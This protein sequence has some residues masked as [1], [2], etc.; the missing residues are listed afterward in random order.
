LQIRPVTLNGSAFTGVWA[1]GVHVNA[2]FGDVS[3]NGVADGLD[4]AFANNV[5]Q[6]KSTGFGAYTLLDPAIIGDVAGDVSVDA[7]DVSSLAA[8]VL[9]LPTPKI[10]AIPTGPA[11]TP[12]GPDPTLSLSEQGGVRPRSLRANGGVINVSVRLDQPHPAGSS[13][14]TEAILAL[15]YDP[16]VLS[17]SAS[18]ITLGSLPSL[19]AGWQLSSVIDAATGQIGIEL[20]S[21]TAITATQ[22]GSLVNIVFHVVPGAPAGKTSVQLVR[23][24]MPG[25]EQFTTQVDA[26]EGSLVLGLGSERLEMLLPRSARARLAF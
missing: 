15:T 21:T 5:A 16:S 1:D 13:G 10:P 14:M 12:T 25:G 6:G 22:G 8:Y 4:V 7:G 26:P 20:Y 23:A 3:G 11:I 17:V 2:Y 19:G 18:D 9:Q 24:V